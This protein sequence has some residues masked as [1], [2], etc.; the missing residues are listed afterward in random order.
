MFA[1]DSFCDILSDEQAENLF[2]HLEFVRDDTSELVYSGPDVFPLIVIAPDSTNI[3]LW[4][5]IHISEKNPDLVICEL[6]LE[7][8]YL[9]PLFSP[10]EEEP[11]PEDTL[12]SSPS[13]QDLLES[14]TSMSRP[15]RVLRHAR[16]RRGQAAAMEV[17][18]L[19]GQI[20]GD[21]LLVTFLF[22]AILLMHF[23]ERT[24]FLGNNSRW[25]PQDS[26]RHCEGTNGFPSC[27]D[28]PIR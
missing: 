17:F 22:L 4:C 23:V 11:G 9:Y 19:M 5:A 21:N 26:C 24:T 14:T 25:F 3:K 18:N 8:D 7:D 13:E 27:H 2:E 15:L 10:A 20:Q 12:G 16:K 1:L 6:E 28:L